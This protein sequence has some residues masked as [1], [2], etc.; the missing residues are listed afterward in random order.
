MSLAKRAGLVRAAVLAAVVGLSLSGCSPDDG[1]SGAVPPVG[2]PRSW[3]W[4]AAPGISLQSAEA[5]TIRG[6]AESRKLY[7]DNKVSY[8]G[9]VEATSPDLL[10]DLVGA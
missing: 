7:Q 9:F 4:Y 6:W 3:I 2:Y 5:R 1:S 10:R 8:T